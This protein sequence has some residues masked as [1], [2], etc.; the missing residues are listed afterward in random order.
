LYDPEAN[1]NVVLNLGPDS[2][3]GLLLYNKDRVRKDNHRRMVLGVYRDGKP[4]MEL[5]DDKENL[6]AAFGRTV[7]DLKRTNV[8]EQHLDK[9][10]SLGDETG[11]LIWQ[12][13]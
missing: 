12:A 2:E 11:K 10:F 5:Y 3:P 13:P 7:L 1:A 6:R 4:G 9:P 8:A